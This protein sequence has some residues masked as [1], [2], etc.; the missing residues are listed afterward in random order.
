MGNFNNRAGGGS[1]PF[2]KPSF[3]GGRGG[4]GG[5]SSRGGFG[6]P[7]RDDGD[8][9]MFTATCAECNNECQVPFRPN[10]RKPVLCSNCFKRDES[11]RFDAPARGANR[12][13]APAPAA[14]APARAPQSFASTS[15]N[16][17]TKESVEAL[18]KQLDV[19]Y[20]KLEYIVKLVSP[21]VTIEPVE[22]DAAPKAKAAPKKA[23][24]AKK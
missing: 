14:A 23:K 24:A 5:P 4:F 7:R 15:T 19:I 13:D 20:S 8:R 16:A 10:G 17:A 18:K 22:E 12:W 3:G 2:H 6:G 9:E 21:V 11:P 1:K